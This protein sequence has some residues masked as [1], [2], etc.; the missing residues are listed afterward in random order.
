MPCPL[1]QGLRDLPDYSAPP[2]NRS[3]IADPMTDELPTSAPIARNQVAA[4]DDTSSRQRKASG[5]AE[6][7]LHF[8][9]DGHDT[10]AS[11]SFRYG[12]PVDALR[13]ANAIWSDNLFH[14]RRTLIIP[15]EFYRTGISLS[16]WPI[17]GEEEEVR[18]RK[19][20]RWMVACK[21]SEC[22][23]SSSCLIYN[24][25]PFHTMLREVTNGRLSAYLT[26]AG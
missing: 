4:G 23:P 24:Q 13:R 5:P 20:R 18:K 16:P 21:V 14:A 12:I 15:S 3:R 17:D 2:S 10:L 25:I 7:V 11:L 26:S 9:D 19:V 6:D 22:V 8:I 1:P